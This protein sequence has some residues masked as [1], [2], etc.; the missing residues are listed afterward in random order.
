MHTKSHGL[1]LLDLAKTNKLTAKCAKAIVVF[2]PNPKYEPELP[3]YC[4]K[5]ERNYV[6]SDEA[7]IE[8][9]SKDEGVLID[10]GGEGVNVVL[11]NWNG[12]GASESER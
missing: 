1:T 4:A 10:F 6:F 8:E 3:T 2:S 7:E 11:W 9:A 12:Q 5:E